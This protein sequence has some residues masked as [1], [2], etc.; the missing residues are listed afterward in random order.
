MDFEEGWICILDIYFL[1]SSHTEYS[2]AE[3]LTV[4]RRFDPFVLIE[5]I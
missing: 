5:P 1:P 4:K 3:G 2:E